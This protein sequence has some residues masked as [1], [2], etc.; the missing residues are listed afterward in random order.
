MIEACGNL[1]AISS[2]IRLLKTGGVYILVGM[3]HPNT[4]LE[5]TGEQII[6]K[7]LTL[8]GVHNYHD[9]HL[10]KAVEFLRQTVHKYP[11]DHVLAPQKFSLDQFLEAIDYAKK[12]EYPRVCIRP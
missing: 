11:F 8:K 12:K 4:N 2:G 1:K 9:K 6:R 10:E 7:C 5:L 3:V